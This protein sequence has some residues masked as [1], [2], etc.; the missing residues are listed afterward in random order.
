MD[1]IREKERMQ[2]DSILGINLGHYW[3]LSV[4]SYYLSR[5]FL[6]IEC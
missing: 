5:L 6:K 2:G 4:L 1:H 3:R